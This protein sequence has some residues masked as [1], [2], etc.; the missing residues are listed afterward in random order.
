MKAPAG[1]TKLL[2]LVAVWGKSYVSLF[3]DIA[4]RSA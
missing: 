2:F 3:T 4:C 1:D